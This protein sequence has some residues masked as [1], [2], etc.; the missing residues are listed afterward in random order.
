LFGCP[1]I[2][3]DRKVKKYQK[4]ETKSV[5]VN[6]KFDDKNMCWSEKTK[7]PV[8]SKKKNRNKSEQV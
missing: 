7:I 3:S 8:V 2:G 6:S 1:V 4:M 5:K